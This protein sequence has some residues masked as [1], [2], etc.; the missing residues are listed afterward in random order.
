MTPLQRDVVQVILGEE[1]ET[2]LSELC[3]CK[4]VTNYFQNIVLPFLNY[5]YQSKAANHFNK[6]D[7]INPRLAGTSSIYK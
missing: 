2:A 1:N 6:H 3:L 5:I 4:V 7:V